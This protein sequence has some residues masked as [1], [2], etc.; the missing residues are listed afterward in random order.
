MFCGHPALADPPPQYYINW[1][2]SAYNFFPPQILPT[3]NGGSVHKNC[4]SHIKKKL[5]SV[6]ESYWPDILL[7]DDLVIKFSKK[8][9]LISDAEFTICFLDIAL[10]GMSVLTN[11]SPDSTFIGDLMLPS[12]RFVTLQHK[13][14]HLLTLRRLM[15]YI[16]GAPILDVSRSHTTTQHSR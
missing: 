2:F 1:W 9:T 12:S 14:R 15:S 4:S 3:L 7:I 13:C 6:H 11:C 16:Y 10:I 8:F 5:V